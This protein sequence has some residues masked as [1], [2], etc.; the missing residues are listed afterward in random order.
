MEY[1]EFQTGTFGRME[2]ER[3]VWKNYWRSGY[4]VT[5]HDIPQL[6]TNVE[7][8]KISNQIREFP[9]ELAAE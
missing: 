2:S 7:N 3:G 8:N 4:A 1:P 6:G 5:F 9:I